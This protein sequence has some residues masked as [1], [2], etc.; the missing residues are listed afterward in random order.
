MYRNYVQHQKLLPFTG[1]T[2][3]SADGYSGYT[4]VNTG[5]AALIIN[6]IITLQQ[7]EQC[8][9]RAEPYVIQGDDIIISFSG[10]GTT[11]GYAV[12]TYNM[13]IKDG[14]Y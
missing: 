14:V 3:I 7:N 8:I 9:F 11:S 12:L 13:E 4:I 6:G 5:T 1:N 10:T 2:K